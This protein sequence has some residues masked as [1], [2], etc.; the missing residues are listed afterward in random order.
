MFFL[1]NFGELLIMEAFM[2]FECELKFLSSCTGLEFLS[3]FT[4]ALLMLTT[5]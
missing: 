3:G 5:S 1:F 4:E 2:S